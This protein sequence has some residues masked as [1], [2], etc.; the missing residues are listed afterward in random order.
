M[1]GLV[2]VI[3]AIWI[4]RGHL[5]MSGHESYYI[6]YAFD[7]RADALLVGC[8]LALMLKE[9]VAQQVLERVCRPVWAPLLT[10]LLI[11]TSVYAGGVSEGYKLVGGLGIEPVLVAILICR[12]I[13]QS[14]RRRGSG[15]IQRPLLIWAKFLTLCTSTTCWPGMWPCESLRISQVRAPAYLQSSASSLRLP[16]PVAATKS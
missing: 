2:A 5:W 10:C 6:T 16:L 4:H 1:S 8:L 13:V 14:A 12:W 11:G 15:L 3:V 9:G 7:T